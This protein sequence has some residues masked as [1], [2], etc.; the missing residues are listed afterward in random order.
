[1][2]ALKP[3]CEENHEEISKIAKLYGEDK[4]TNCNQAIQILG[5]DFIDYH[6]NQNIQNLCCIKECVN[7][8]LFV[9][10]FKYKNSGDKKL[11]KN[12]NLNEFLVKLDVTKK[13]D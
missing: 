6:S 7:G 2:C 11:D 9:S 13:L 5:C 1:M 12:E 4:I 8:N 3:K 10:L